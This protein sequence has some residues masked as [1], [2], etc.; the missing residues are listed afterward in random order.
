ML[1]KPHQNPYHDAD[2]NLIQRINTCDSS[3]IFLSYFTPEMK[4]DL[5]DALDGRTIDD[6]D[7]VKLIARINHG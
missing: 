7:Y 6:A 2:A 3:D 4:T 5:R 1:S